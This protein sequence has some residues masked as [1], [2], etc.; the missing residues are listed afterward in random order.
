MHFGTTL[1]LWTL[2]RQ[3]AASREYLRLVLGRE[4]TRQE[5]WRHFYTFTEYLILRMAVCQGRE[6]EVAFAPGHGAEARAWVGQGKPA[7]YGTMHVGRSDLVGFFLCDLGA[8]VH[9]VRRQVGNSEDTRRLARRFERSVTFIWINDWSKM[10][11]AMND[12]LRDGRSLAMQCD[13]PEHSSKHEDFKFL[14]ARRVF[15]FT[16]YHLAIMHRMPV[17]MSYAVPDPADSARTVV[18]MPPMFLPRDEAS[19]QENFAAA[20]DH[21]QAFLREIEDLLRTN[22]YL[23]F[24]FEPMNPLSVVRQG[25]GKSPVS[26]GSGPVPGIGEFDRPARPLAPG[27]GVLT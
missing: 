15:P 16:I 25:R 22:P 5:V 23:W 14:G 26:E 24:N 19:R 18:Y 12:A 11:L 3:R 27:K 7:L 20:R 6:A 2:H 4:P 21:Y 8:R 10:I 9:M 1:A 13:R 17:I